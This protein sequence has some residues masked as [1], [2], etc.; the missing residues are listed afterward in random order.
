MTTV[1]RI[2]LENQL[3]ILNALES[4]TDGPNLKKKLYDRFVITHD[5]IDKVLAELVE[6][7]S[8]ESFHG[9]K[10]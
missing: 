6:N 3:I 4:L 10:L 8:K 9:S 7:Q 2:V 1:E 5:Y